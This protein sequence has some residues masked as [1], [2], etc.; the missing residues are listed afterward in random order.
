MLTQNEKEKIEQIFSSRAQITPIPVVNSRNQAPAPP[1]KIFQLQRMAN[2]YTLL[3]TDPNS[4]TTPFLDGAFLFVILSSDP[5]RIYC[6]TPNYRSEFVIEGHTSLS[7]RADVL[8]AGE[9]FFRHG[10]LEKWTNGSGHYQPSAALRQTNLIPYLQLL[11]PAEK[12]VDQWNTTSSEAKQRLWD[13]GYAMLD[14]GSSS[15]GN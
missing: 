14:S 12:F 8:Y 2:N 1:S 6:G 5:A 10:E 15:S 11:L 3:P 13:R 4:I 9:L 7:Y